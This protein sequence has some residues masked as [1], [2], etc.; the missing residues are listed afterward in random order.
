[1]PLWLGLVTHKL[2][3]KS[4]IRRRIFTE[5]IYALIFIT[6]GPVQAGSPASLAQW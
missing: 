6:G 4:D 2:F 3:V 1:M 5:W